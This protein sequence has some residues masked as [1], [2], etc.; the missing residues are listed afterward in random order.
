[1]QQAEIPEPLH[2]NQ[3]QHKYNSTKL[4]TT[5]IWR[6]SLHAEF[7]EEQ[8]KFNEDRKPQ[9]MSNYICWF[10]DLIHCMTHINN[11]RGPAKGGGGGGGPMSPV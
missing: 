9:K 1:M 7:A 11:E 10:K 3:E 6:I 2:K 8:T 4:M 5:D